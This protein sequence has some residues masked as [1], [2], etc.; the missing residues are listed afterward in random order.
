VDAFEQALADWEFSEHWRPVVARFAERARDWPIAVL[1][2]LDFWIQKASASP[3]G[4]PC[5]GL[6]IWT[7]VDHPTRNVVVASIGGQFDPSGLR[8]GRLEPHNPAGYGEVDDFAWIVHAH[9]GLSLSDQADRLIEWFAHEAER[10]HRHL[11][12]SPDAG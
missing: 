10:W 6:L 1:S 7:D 8:V 2:P 9:D 11:V 5:D 4:R 3:G 12:R